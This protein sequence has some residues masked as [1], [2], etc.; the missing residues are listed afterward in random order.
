MSQLF[1]KTTK[2]LDHLRNLT[3]ILIVASKKLLNAIGM[4]KEIH[5]DLSS[6][7]ENKL[8]DNKNCPVCNGV[9]VVSP[10]ILKGHICINCGVLDT[11]F[12][13]LYEAINKWNKLLTN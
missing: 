4:S 5:S 11:A 13:E 1:E 3:E 2:K 10:T 8:D 12:K 7:L 6:Y 9:M